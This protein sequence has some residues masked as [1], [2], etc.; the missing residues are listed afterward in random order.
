MFNTILFPVD[1]SALSYKPMQ[2]VIGLAKMSGS[3]VV[4]LSVA[5]PRLFSSSNPQDIRNGNVVEAMNTDAARENVQ[6]VRVLAERA[7]VPCESVVSMSHVPREEII[8]TVQ[9]RNCDLIVMAT[10]GKMGVIDTI[11]SESTTQDVIRSSPVP[12]L[13]F[14]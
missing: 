12:V 11:F 14:P 2:A 6:K 10:R 8:D 5:A 4:V 7:G 9:K 13:V 1:G 3:S